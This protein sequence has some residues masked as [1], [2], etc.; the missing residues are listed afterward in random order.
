MRQ[1]MT[2]V[3]LLAS[4]IVVGCGSA[5]PEMYQGAKMQEA[6]LARV[7][8]GR[9]RIIDAYHNLAMKA[10]SDQLDLIAER[11]IAKATTDGKIAVEDVA[12]LMKLKDEKRAE[13]TALLETKRAEFLKD[14]NLDIAVEINR[15]TSA[16]I[17]TYVED[18]AAR[19]DQLI[20]AGQA[21]GMQLTK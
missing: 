4:T 2:A 3:L 17:K 9:E 21:I 12:R 18:F 14:D 11:E 15:V 7:Q 8:E 1:V 6:A 10:Y 5:P 13:F 16:W 20:A 19:I